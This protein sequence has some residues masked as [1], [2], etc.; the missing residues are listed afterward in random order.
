MLII[1]ASLLRRLIH[2]PN[3]AASSE[4]EEARSRL[5]LPLISWKRFSEILHCRQTRS[6]D[7]HIVYL[8]LL[9]LFLLRP[10]VEVTYTI[11]AL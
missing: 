7:H 9:S 1:K 6:S 4:A 10:E 8:C 2:R 11:Q 3:P 5:E